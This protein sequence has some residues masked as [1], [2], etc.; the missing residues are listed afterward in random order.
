MFKSKNYLLPFHELL[1]FLTQKIFK[2]KIRAL[3]IVIF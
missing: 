2:N 1:V 3:Q